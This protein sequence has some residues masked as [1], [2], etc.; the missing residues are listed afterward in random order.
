MLPLT[1]AGLLAAGV[2]TLAIGNM[3]H[4]PTG[5]M[6]SISMPRIIAALVCLVCA[7]GTALM[8]EPAFANTNFRTRGE[9]YTLLLLCTIGMHLLCLAS[10]M[11]M[12]FI[13]IEMMG[14]CLYVM[15][16]F[17][18]KSI[19]SQEAAFKYFL[20]AAFASSFLLMGMAMIYG[21]TGSTSLEGIQAAIRSGSLLS[22]AWAQL[23]LIL[24]FTAFCFKLTFAPF[25]MYAS[26][27][28][29]GSPT[30]TCSL[31]ATGSKVAGF[32]S[33]AFIIEAMVVSPL[34]MSGD[35]DS[36]LGDRALL[37][38]MFV[39]IISMAFGNLGAFVQNDL[40]RLLAYSSIAHA[41]YAGMGFIGLTVGLQMANA[42]LIAQSLNGITYYL[43]AYAFMTILAFGVLT[44]LGEEVREK[45]DLIGLAKRSPML[46]AALAVAM[47]SLTGLPP[48]VGFFGKFQVFMAAVNA[49]HTTLAVLGVIFSVLSAY[50]YLHL[51]V[52]MYF[53]EVPDD[54]DEPT[55]DSQPW[56]LPEFQANASRILVAGMFLVL[57]GP[58]FLFG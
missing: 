58:L 47:I 40:R 43:L 30:P 12:I 5:E 52:L 6:L 28:Y 22:G 57:A 8:T 55:A 41:G 23:G 56:L 50:Y 2:S 10:E 44:M 24:I 54:A 42:D 14:L 15:A 9:Y 38:F 51:I 17:H 4:L 3:N 25:H 11:V 36:Y 45:S 31:I 18:H 20:L 13:A 27:V 49:G 1:L 33:L 29:E 34:R 46:A 35:T 37:M 32:V 7:A 26:D 53:T 16:G 48:T 19:A 39:S 21:A